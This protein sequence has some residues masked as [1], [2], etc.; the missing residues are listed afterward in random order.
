MLERIVAA[1]RRRLPDLEERRDDILRQA[2]ETP[3]PPSFRGALSGEGM[4][5]VAEVKRRSPSRG[6]LAPDLDPSAQAARYAQGGAA[7]ISVLTEPEFFSGSPADLTAVSLATGL[8]VLRKDFILSPEQVWEGRAIGASAVLLI[9]A[10]LEDPPLRHLLAVSREAGLDALVEVHTPREAERAVE[11]GA[12]IVG[13]N[14]R[15][16]GD[17]TVDLATSEKLAPLLE[18]VPVTVSESGVFG[19]EEVRRLAEAGYDAVLVGEAL[20]TADDPAA[21]VRRLRAV[22]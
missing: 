6:D 4:A 16:L 22:R 8:P 19:V 5:V 2:T 9:A 15:D 11:A 12:E 7:A 13:V 3:P 10:I 18:P 14:N 21:L 20:V 17:F 1:T